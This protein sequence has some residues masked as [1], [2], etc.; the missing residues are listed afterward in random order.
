MMA[1]KPQTRRITLF[2]IVSLAA[3]AAGYNLFR[4]RSPLARATRVTITSQSTLLTDSFTWMPPNSLFG[5]HGSRPSW[6]PYT[7][8]F[9]TSQVERQEPLRKLIVS[10]QIVEP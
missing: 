6:Y 10:Q 8:N 9:Q 4:S 3:I 7:F 1:L 5:F 2:L